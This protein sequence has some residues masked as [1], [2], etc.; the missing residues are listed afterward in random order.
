MNAPTLDTLEARLW[1]RWAPPP[2]L[3]VSQWADEYRVLSPEASAEPGRWSTARVPYLREVMD[4]MNDP[5]VHTI[6]LQKSSQSAGTEAILNMIGYSMH[7][8]PGPM[9]LIEP[10][11]EMAGAIAK[12]RIRPMLRDSVVLRD[13]V[14]PPRTKDSTNTTL[15]M[16]FRG[17]M[18]TLAG[19]NST[20]GLA[21]RPIQRLFV[22]EADRLPASLPSEGDP[23]LLALAR[24]RTFRRRKVVIVSSP[25]TKSGSR[26][27]D[28]HNISDRRTFTTPC[29]RCETPFVLAWEHV[30]WQERDP[31][32]S[33]LECPHCAGRIEDGERPAMIAAGVWRPTAPFA[34]IAGFHVWELMAPWRSL[35]EQVAAFLASRHSLE[36]H[37]AWTNTALG[38]VWEAPG[39][40]VDAGSLLLRRE[41]YPA[42]LPAGVV[43]VVAGVDVQDS[44]LATLIL[45]VGVGEESWVVDYQTLAGDPARP[46][47][48]QALDALLDRTWQHELGLALPVVAAFIDSG[49]HRTQSVYSYVMPRQRARRIACKG[50]SGGTHGM[51]VSPAKPVRPASGPGFIQLRH[52]DVDQ[53]KALLYSRLRLAE[54]SGPEVVHFPLSVGEQ[55]FSE[56]TAEKLITKRNKYGVPTKVWEQQRSRNEAID[57]LC[58]ALGALRLVATPARLQEWATR[59]TAAAAAQSTPAAPPVVESA[60]DPADPPAPLPLPRPPTGR[61]TYRSSFMDRLRVPPRNWR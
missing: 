60:G 42:E 27:E 48:W 16:A 52:V 51:M 41:A 25:T 13:L 46:E 11:L 24:T 45:G 2:Q 20:A 54:R 1:A 8:D 35:A 17:G 34:G 44:Y 56:L 21:S 61:R 30:R 15:H 31:A 3:K 4:A 38:R 47:V 37:Q 10:T 50:Q 57:C 36:M 43:C 39:E 29:P 33:Y 26:I 14:A 18:L 55:F 5:R 12:D 40:S 28:W 49:G 7:L 22:D 23:L 6:V 32:T 19:G 58:Y 53:C 9:L 59:I